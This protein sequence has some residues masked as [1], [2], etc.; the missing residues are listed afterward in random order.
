LNEIYARTD[1][2]CSVRLGAELSRALE[3]ADGLSAK[4]EAQSIK[5]N[6]VE[7]ERDHFKAEARR[8]EQERDNAVAYRYSAVA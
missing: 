2:A 3:A 6:F 1:K 8:L 5:L 4:L 7:L